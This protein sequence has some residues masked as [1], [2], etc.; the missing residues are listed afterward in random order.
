MGRVPGVNVPLALSENDVKPVFSVVFFQIYKNQNTDFNSW[1]VSS[2]QYELFHF[3]QR[4]DEFKAVV[5]NQGSATPRGSAEVL[6]GVI[7]LKKKKMAILAKIICE[8]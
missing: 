7:Q 1:T 5:F 8:S 3:I 2:K 6:H 4:R